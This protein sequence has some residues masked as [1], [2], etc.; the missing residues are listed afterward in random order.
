[1]I[2]IGGLA[3]DSTNDRLVGL[4][5]GRP[6]MLYEI[7]R[8]TAALGLLATYGLVDSCGIAWD[9]DRELFWSMECGGTFS[10]LDPDNG[11]AQSFHVTTGVSLNQSCGMAYVPIPEPATLG[12]LALGGVALVRRRSRS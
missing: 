1:M 3:Y 5:E 4:H 7:D 2:N 9:S 12:L 11:Y 6:A 8:T 10:S